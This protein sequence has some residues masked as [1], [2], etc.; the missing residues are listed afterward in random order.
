MSPLAAREDG[1]QV[2]V[3][4]AGSD[5]SIIIA[6]APDGDGDGL[7]D[8][9]DNC[10]RRANADQADEDGDDVGNAC[11]LKFVPEPGRW[12]LSAT[13]LCALALMQ[14]RRR[15]RA[16]TRARRSAAAC[17]SLVLSTAGGVLLFSPGDASA[18]PFTPGDILVGSA[19]TG[20]ILHLNPKGRF[21]RSLR[22][23]LR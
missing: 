18:Q 2:F 9:F 20:E 19:T 1:Q 12:I 6:G 23:F 21:I 16:S 17:I 8:P 7:A 5:A 3:S 14:T 15:T 11:D 13:A 22:D 4:S 10:P